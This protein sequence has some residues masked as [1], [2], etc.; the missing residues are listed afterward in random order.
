ML[1]VVVP[2]WKQARSQFENEAL[3]NVFPL[4]SFLNR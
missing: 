2:E 1:N 4:N 3:P